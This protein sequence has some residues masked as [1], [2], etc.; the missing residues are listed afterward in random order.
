M[1][2]RFAARPRS[3][4]FLFLF[5]GLRARRPVDRQTKEWTMKERHR[6]PARILAI[7]LGFALALQGCASDGEQPD[8]EG[9]HEVTL[10]YQVGDAEVLVEARLTPDGLFYEG[11]STITR[12]GEQRVAFARFPATHEAHAQ[13][14]EGPEGEREIVIDGQRFP[15]TSIDETGDKTTIEFEGTDG[16]RFR[17]TERGES[18]FVVCGGVCIAALVAAAACT[19]YVLYVITSCWWNDGCWTYSLYLCSGSCDENWES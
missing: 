5:L 14:E 2:A 10:E 19:G 13:L 18:P 3:R 4:V 7:G 12:D 8:T 11:T 17:Y 15:V 9:A 1:G 6:T 16:V